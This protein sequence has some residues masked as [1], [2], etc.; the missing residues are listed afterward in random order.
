MP[1]PVRDSCVDVLEAL[2]VKDALADAVPL[3][4]GAK[5]TLNDTLLPA[6]RV[7][8]KESPL[9]LN[10][11]VLMPALVIVMLEPVAVKDA[12]RLLLC[13]T[14]TLPKLNVA[15]LTANCPE[16]VAVPAMEMVSEESVASEITETDPEALPPEVGANTVPKVKLCPEA[17][18]IGSV[19]PVTRKPVPVTAAWLTVT[20][21]PPVLVRVSD[22]VALPFTGTLPKLMLESL[23]LRTPAVAEDPEAIPVPETGTSRAVGW[24]VA[25]ELVTVP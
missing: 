22:W 17:S 21:E 4:W 6:A 11:D 15:G 20:L 3:D 1:L 14:V 10:S 9:T 23:V 13:P 5:L 16:T 2:L 12:G 24:V 25:A 19:N 8:G 7:I 18:V